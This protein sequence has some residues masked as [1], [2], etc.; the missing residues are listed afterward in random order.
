[1]ADDTYGFSYR[2]TKGAYSLTHVGKVLEGAP[3][4]NIKVVPRKIRVQVLDC[5][6]GRPLTRIP[7]DSIKID[8][9]LVAR[10][11]A[12]AEEAGWDISKYFPLFKQEGWWK[13]GANRRLRKAGKKLKGLG[14]AS[15]LALAWLGFKPGTIGGESYSL[16]TKTAFLRY[17]LWHDHIDLWEPYD[18]SQFFPIIVEDLDEPLVFPQQSHADAENEQLMLEFRILTQASLEKTDFDSEQKY[19]RDPFH[20]TGT[21]E[22]IRVEPSEAEMREIIDTYNA[23]CFRAMKFH[24]A[25]L[26]YFPPNEDPL[27]DCALDAKDDWEWTYAWKK[28]FFAWQAVEYPKRKK[29]RYWDWVKRSREGKKL[30]AQKRGVSDNDGM[31]HVPVPVSQFKEDFSLE[32]RL[33][34]CSIAAEAIQHE[35]DAGGTN[36]ESLIF[37]T[38]SGATGFAIEWVDDQTTNVDAW[39]ASWG[40]R[41]GPAPSSTKE[42]REAFASFKTSAKFQIHG[43]TDAI[44]EAA[45]NEVESGQ[46]K[47]LLKALHE[48]KGTFSKFYLNSARAPEF[49]VFAMNWCQPVWDN[50]D[51]VTFPG[52]TEKT[53]VPEGSIPG[54]HMH[55]P[56]L[57]SSMSGNELYGGKGYG[58]YEQGQGPNNWKWRSGGH[59]GIDV[60]AV[61]GDK[62]FAVHAGKVTNKNTTWTDGYLLPNKSGKYVDL[63]WTDPRHLSLI[64]YL[65]L[66]AFDIDVSEPEKS[67]VKAGQIVGRA[68][69]TGNLGYNKLDNGPPHWTPANTIW[70]GHCHLW[71]DN[72]AGYSSRLS[73]T[74]DPDNRVCIPNNDFPLLFPC[75]ADV[76]ATGATNPND[77]KFEKWFASQCWAVAELK[78]PHMPKDSDVSLA[79]LEGASANSKKRKRVQAQLR[80]LF[81]NPPEDVVLSHPGIL[82]GKFGSSSVLITANTTNI[83]AAANMNNSVGTARKGQVFRFRAEV[84]NFYRISYKK[85]ANRYVS[86]NA[87]DKVGTRNAIRAF[88]TGFAAEIGEEVPEG[89]A[90]GQMTEA[91]LSVLNTHAAVVGPIKG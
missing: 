88:R 13:Q 34:E 51:D 28:V 24:L 8:G 32:I 64:Q 80:Y 36:G 44:K 83:Y 23:R 6:S 16:Q 2:C 56:T 18:S 30:M 33:A 40:W 38:T 75:A 54:V 1:M 22:K 78:C 25:S 85:G 35:I 5:R 84:G 74:P 52:I 91:A 41:I 31:I 4:K 29:S 20:D 46:R 73:Q 49:V 87:S 55:I 82:H 72:R 53:Y 11:T 90:G 7:I 70:P 65:H 47:G 58:K 42:T 69:R 27:D 45:N 67:R 76:T 15:Q 21:K 79:D 60:H 43:V 37:R 12:S 10:Y 81:D 66:N 17:R 77:C 61:V 9:K 62:L 63:R 14:V 71:L 86:K 48:A 59:K 57:A 3:Q 39:D 68:G 50:F 19:L 26:G 89:D